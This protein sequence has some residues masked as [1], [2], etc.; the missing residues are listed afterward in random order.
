[1]RRTIREQR[2]VLTA[3]G[4]CLALLLI[5]IVSVIVDWRN[6]PKPTVPA[7][8]WQRFKP[9]LGAAT[10]EFPGAPIEEPEFPVKDEVNQRWCF[11]TEQFYFE[12]TVSQFSDKGARNI[13]RNVFRATRDRYLKIAKNQVLRDLLT[14]AEGIFEKREELVG[15]RYSTRFWTLLIWR[16]DCVYYLYCHGEASKEGDAVCRRFL[17]SIQ[18]EE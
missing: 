11:R 6:A 18:F 2:V 3:L 15:K 1:M 14:E 5:S 8:E 10:I 13:A 17:D 7:L 9:M 4:L 16:G 12:F